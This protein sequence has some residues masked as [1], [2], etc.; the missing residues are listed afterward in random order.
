ME[1]NKVALRAFYETRK[2]AY[3]V[4]RNSGDTHQ[5]DEQ[6][7]WDV[8]PA[9]NKRLAGFAAIT[10]DNITEFMSIITNNSNKS[11]FAHWIDMDDLTMLANLN[12]GNQILDIV[13]T[14]KPDDVCRAIDT[15]NNISNSFPPH[16]KFSPSTWGYILAA[17]DCAKFAIYRD[18][19][20]KEL[21]EINMP[22]KTKGLTQGEKYSLL[23]KSANYLGE[24]IRSDNTGDDAYSQTALNGQDFLW[25]SLV[26]YN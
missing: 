17:K 8:L 4:R 9:L 3:Y 23:N 25:V 12:Y 13:W 18:V 15:A 14:A 24:L 21:I 1:I 19:V 10:R 2:E 26:K 22:A 11:N 6:Y 20:V 7:K 16:K 5:W